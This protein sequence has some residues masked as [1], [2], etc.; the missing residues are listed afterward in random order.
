MSVRDQI[1]VLQ[2]AQR[3]SLSL[4]PPAY[5]TR[6]KPLCVPFSPS[7]V[8][9]Q[10]AREREREKEKGERRS[11]TIPVALV[12]GVSRSLSAGSWCSFAR[13][14]RRKSRGSHP[15]YMAH[16]TERERE[17]EME[18]RKGLSV[19]M[20]WLSTPVI[21]YG[22]S[23]GSQHARASTFKDGARTFSPIPLSLGS[24]CLLYRLLKRVEIKVANLF[25]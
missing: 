6:R 21:K 7:I 12:V 22:A 20:R 18:K 23:K 25:T 24:S 1:I 15:G 13:T 9:E 14:A 11:K 16:T 3:R 2:G 19:Y 8:L 4:S 10:R 5:L 17:R